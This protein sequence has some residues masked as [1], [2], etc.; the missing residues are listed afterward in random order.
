MV[1][2]KAFLVMDVTIDQHTGGDTQRKTQDIDQGKALVTQQV[3]RGSPEGSRSIDHASR[4]V[5]LIM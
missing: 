4:N 1:A 2:V 3:A 5:Y